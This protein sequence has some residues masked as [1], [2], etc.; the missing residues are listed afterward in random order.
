MSGL[1]MY[2]CNV[3]PTHPTQVMCLTERVAKVQIQT[4]LRNI[5]NVWTDPV[6]DT[7]QTK[8]AAVRV[9]QL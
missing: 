6:T 7:Y 5:T 3:S 4:K 8:L 1:F 2:L 9:S